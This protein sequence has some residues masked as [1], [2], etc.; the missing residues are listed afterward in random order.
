MRAPSSMTLKTMSR[1]QMN[2]R[3]ALKARGAGEVETAAG[4]LLR[5]VAVVDGSRH[6]AVN[7]TVRL[8]L[9]GLGG[10]AGHLLGQR[11]VDAHGHVRTVLLKGANRDEHDSVARDLLAVRKCRPSPPCTRCISSY[12]LTP[13]L[14]GG[15]RMKPAPPI[16]Q[17]GAKAR[18]A[19]FGCEIL[20]V[21]L[22]TLRGCRPGPC[23]HAG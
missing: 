10:G 21:S 19:G 5:A 14:T 12:L 13:L 9:E 15:V 20:A 7:R 23:L 6:D 16:A 22:R 4:T 1:A 2:E 3:F 11:G 8:S 17:T 18:G